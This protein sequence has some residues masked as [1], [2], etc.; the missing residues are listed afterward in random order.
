V[1]QRRASHVVKQKAFHRPDAFVL[2]HSASS[3]YFDLKRLSSD[4]PKP[5]AR[6][7]DTKRDWFKVI[8][9][10]SGVLQRQYLSNASVVQSFPE[11]AV[12]AE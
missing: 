7:V 3:L 6:F 5:V 4:A 10:S 12:D 9:R 8:Y 1:T 11:Q 2:N